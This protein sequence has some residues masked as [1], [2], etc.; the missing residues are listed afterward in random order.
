VVTDTVRGSTQR[1]ATAARIYDYCLGGVHN[2]PADREV[3]RKLIEQF[4]FIPAVARANRAFLGRAV[5]Y[6]T[7]VGIRQ[8]LDLGSGIP[9]VG[10]VHE[11][12]QAIAPDS[13]VV[14]VDIDPVAIADSLEILDG[15]PS[16]TAILADLRS[17]QTVLAHPAVRRLL[18]FSQPM[19]VLLASVLHFV[20]DDQ[21][22][23][24]AVDQ[25]V[26]TLAPGSYLV[27]SHA[28]TENFSPSSGREELAELYKRQTATAGVARDR[29]QFGRFLT[30]LELVEPGLVWTRD[31]RPDPSQPAPSPDDRHGS[32]EWAAVGRK[33]ENRPPSQPAQ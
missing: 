24:E 3:A 30:G 19:T 22:A 5:R 28:A 18:D 16:A 23:Y 29:S 14:Y 2:F 9:T 13:R 33:V 4:P 1:P 20:P 7:D 10:N 15:N 25:Y 11:V 21:Q 6:L 31:W 32:G 27:V 17:P 26:D 12:A 8:F